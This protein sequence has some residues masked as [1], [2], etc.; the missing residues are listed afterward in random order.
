MLGKPGTR[1]VVRALATTATAAPAG[2][3]G[4]M[5][6]ASRPSAPIPAAALTLP[7]GAGRAA[8]IP[9][10]LTQFSG[11]VATCADSFAARRIRPAG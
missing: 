1:T 2:A 8:P 7:T 6:A 10:F 9:G 4:L 3:A 11:R 5:L